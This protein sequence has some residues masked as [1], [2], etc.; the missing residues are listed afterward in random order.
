M[1]S[2]QILSITKCN[3]EKNLN[4]LAIPIS[5]MVNKNQY[6]NLPNYLYND[7]Q[8][9]LSDENINNLIDL[10][11]INKTNKSNKT[12]KATRK[13]NLIKNDEKTKKTKKTKNN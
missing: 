10:I 7:S 1:E 2:I 11:N 13:K 9:P 12:N 5:Y 4:N 3:P 8:T 6:T